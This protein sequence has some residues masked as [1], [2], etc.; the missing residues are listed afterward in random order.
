MEQQT[1]V[2][3]PS[4]REVRSTVGLGVSGGQ[5][6]EGKDAYRYARRRLGFIEFWRCR[7]KDIFR[8]FFSGAGRDTL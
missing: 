1:T 3:E 5:M 8:N 2:E 7:L 4:L 6:L